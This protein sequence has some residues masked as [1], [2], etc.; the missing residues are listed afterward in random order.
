MKE[1]KIFFSKYYYLTILII[2][3]NYVTRRYQDSYLG[4]FWTLLAPASQ[5]TIYALVMPRIMKFPSESYVPFLIS[6]LLFWTFINNVIVASAASITSNA[7][8]ITRCLVSKTI[9]PLAEL[10]QHLYT[11][12]IAVLIGYTFSCFAYGTFNIKVLLLP[13]YLIPVLMALIPVLIAFAFITVYIKD[14][15]ELIAILMNFAFWATPI[16]YPIEIFPEEKR[17][18]FYFNPFYIMMK[19]ISGLLFKGDIPSSMDMLRLGALIIIS[20]VVSYAIY[21]KLRRN[22]IYYL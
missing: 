2:A 17:F 21:R 13:I 6:S 3:R 7:A 20:G 1:A 12:F 4:A 22:F 18:I 19:P 9:F 16:I 5:I 11:F 15:K 10:A 8:T 14:F